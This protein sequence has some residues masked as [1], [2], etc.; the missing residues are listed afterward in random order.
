[1]RDSKT[2][3]SEAGKLGVPDLSLF[4]FGGPKYHWAPLFDKGK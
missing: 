3:T 2:K 1:M 4:Y